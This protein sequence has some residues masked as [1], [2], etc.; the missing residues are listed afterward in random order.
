MQDKKCNMTIS[1]KS[2]EM[3]EQSKYLGEPLTNQNS[4]QEEIQNRLKSGNACYHSPQILLSCCSLSKN[5]K[6]E[7]YRNIILPVGLYG[8]ETWFV[9]S[10]EEQKLRA[11]EKSLLRKILGSRKEEVTEEWRRLRNEELYDLHYSPNI[12]VVKSEE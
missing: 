4:V 9:K 11:F 10:R 8:G 5:I 6:S 3:V 7:I 1:D 12:R 2:F